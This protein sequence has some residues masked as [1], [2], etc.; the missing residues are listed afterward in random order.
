[1]SK[2]TQSPF[3]RVSEITHKL[4]VKNLTKL[5]YCPICKRDDLIAFDFSEISSF[6]GMCMKCFMDKKTWKN[7]KIKI[8]LC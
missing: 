7:R 1:M 8:K 3:D 6:Y 5:R 2:E 4:L